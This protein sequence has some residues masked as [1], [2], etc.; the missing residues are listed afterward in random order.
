MKRYFVLFVV[1]MAVMAAKAQQTW[2]FTQEISSD[3]AALNAATT[4]WSYDGDKNRFESKKAI[5]GV[6]KAGNTELQL[7]KGLK[8]KAAEK[9]IRIDVA[10]RVQLAGSN[11]VITI[12]ALKKGQK[13]TV[14]CAS[15]GD[16]AVTL[17]VLTNLS[18]VSG[19]AAADKNTTQPGTATVTQDGDVT[20]AC[21]GG[22]IN[23]FSISVSEAPEGGSETGTETGNDDEVSNNV[24]MNLNQ[25]Q[26]ILTLQSNDVKYYN[27]DELASIDIED[28]TNKVTVNTLADAQDVFNGSVKTIAFSKAAEQG[29]EGDINNGGVEITESKGWFES[30]YAK[31]KP[32]EGATNYH[33]YIKGGKYSDWTKIDQQ[34]VRNYGTYG[35]A[36][37]VGLVA[38][39]DYELKVVP[40]VNEAE[41]T[42]NASTVSNLNVIN[43][44][45]KGFAF[46]DN[47]APGA[48]NSDG[49]LKSN[50]VVI[51]L[52]ILTFIEA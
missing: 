45:R 17:D 28:Q 27:T 40:V 13:V 19:L 8:F 2:D 25:N 12:P 9:K 1:L 39:S 35:R 7:T 49:S 34:L 24:P 43:Y 37:V 46:K 3:V 23:I 21:S 11:V 4:E 15:T 33:V 30:L 50:A 20:M 48:Y 10:K 29:E 18:D 41:S 36:D 14:S 51:Y 42:S 26:A 44:S 31:W 5:D 6:L 38:A 47:Y 16:K 52:T 22:S 32:F